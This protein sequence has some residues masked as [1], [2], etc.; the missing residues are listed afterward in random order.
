MKYKLE[1]YDAFFKKIE[2]WRKQGKKIIFC[3]DV[4]TA[5]NEIDLARPKENSD[6][7]GFLRIERDWLDKVTAA[8]YID[9]F[10]FLHPSEIKYSW[11]DMKTFARE[12]NVGWRIDYFFVSDNLKKKIQVAEILNNVFG[13]DHCPVIL[14]VK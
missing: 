6:H 5:H 1:F 7:T 2:K 12:R 14:V 10:R 8:G 13:S 3:G 9:T 4:N 11:W